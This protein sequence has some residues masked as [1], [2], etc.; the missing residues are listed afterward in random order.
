MET[1]ITFGSVQVSLIITIL[2]AIVYSHVP[3]LGNQWKILIALILGLGFGIL[4]IPYDELP[5]TV[6]NV[7]NNLLQGFMVG[8]SAVGLDQMRRNAVKS[9]TTNTGK[10]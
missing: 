10:K 1:E 2:L 7:V 5:W 4:K 3:S 6:V 8:A 9:P